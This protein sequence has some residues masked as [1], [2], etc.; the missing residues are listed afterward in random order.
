MLRRVS[1]FA[2]PVSPLEILAHLRQADREEAAL[3]ESYTREAVHQLETVCERAIAMAEYELVI[4]TVPTG[5]DDTVGPL[6]FSQ[7]YP[8]QYPGTFASDYYSNQRFTYTF[9][10]AILLEMPP[11]Q[12]IRDFRYW[13]RESPS[14]LETWDAENYSLI[15]ESA[16]K[17]YPA[18]TSA[19]GN[20]GWPSVASR[21]DAVTIRFYAG[22]TDRLNFRA[23][24]PQWSSASGFP[25]SD[26][27]RIHLRVSG[28]NNCFLG[29]TAAPPTGFTNDTTYFVRDY[30]ESTG[31]F[32][33]AA[34]A[35]GEAI[36]GT[37]TMQPQTELGWLYAGHMNGV[38]SYALRKEITRSYVNRCDEGSCMCSGQNADDFR[39]ESHLRR[40]LW[41][42][43]FISQ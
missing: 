36:A 40:L 16:A 29:N 28:N 43:P 34:T 18:P 37:L 3:V 11:V 14:E 26:G 41:R 17:L 9:P 23:D 8:G 20:G 24:T 35:D 13:N 25:Y 10:P 33:L 2:L 22:E 7:N 1:E 4:P 38:T 5:V 32:N 6:P 27:D 30:D 12:A 31:W 15:P 19:S 39:Y 21:V 42:S